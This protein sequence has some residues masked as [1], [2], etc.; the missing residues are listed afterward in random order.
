MRNKIKGTNLILEDGTNY[1]I[2]SV[3]G[4]LLKVYGTGGR[5]N[6]FDKETTAFILPEF[7]YWAR[8]RALRNQNNFY[9]VYRVPVFQDPE[10][11]N[12]WYNGIWIYKEWEIME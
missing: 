12:L 4:T 5:M 3:Y 10:E 7:V 8:I 11:M 1:Y 6:F 9:T 2:D